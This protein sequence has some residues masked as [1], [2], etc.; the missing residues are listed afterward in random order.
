MKYFL[1]LLTL[2]ACGGCRTPS[3]R[4]AERMIT[5]VVPN[6]EEGEELAKERDSLYEEVLTKLKTEGGMAGLLKAAQLTGAHKRIETYGTE[7]DLNKFK[8]V[9]IGGAYD[10]A[11]GAIAY[12]GAIAFAANISDGKKDGEE[13]TQPGQE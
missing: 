5:E 11:D 3:E 13:K 4:L 1:L 6:W 8:L 7:N 2:L 9:V 10:G 12:D